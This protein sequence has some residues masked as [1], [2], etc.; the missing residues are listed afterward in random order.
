MKLS[1][2]RK[3]LFYIDF[4]TCGVPSEVYDCRL[5]NRSASEWALPVPSA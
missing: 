5:G 3:T 1:K 4:L 2:D